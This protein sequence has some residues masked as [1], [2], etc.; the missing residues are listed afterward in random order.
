MNRVLI[1]EDEAGLARFLDR[2]LAAN[3][4]ATRVCED[5]ASALWLADERDFDLL[6]LDLELPDLDGTEVVRRLRE[7]GDDLPVI[8]LDPEEGGQDGGAALDAGADDFV[9]RPFSL[10]E[11]LGRVRARLRPRRSVDATVIETGDVTLDLRTRRATVAGRGID[12][13]DR[14]SSILETF[15]RHPNQ[16]LSQEQIVSYVW[17]YDY[18][19]GSN[20]VE[21]YVGYLRRKLGGGTIET[22]RG[23]GYRLR[24]DCG[25]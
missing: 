13:T 5:G 20:L 19:P 17:G 3:G 24:P 10:E 18:D 23:M 6:I 2:A 16:I 11:I 14:E 7:R 1:V 8:V 12:L 22:V 9:T 25:E 15:M 21:V 4:Y